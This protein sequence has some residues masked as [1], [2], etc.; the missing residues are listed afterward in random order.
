MARVH[1]PYTRD[2]AGRLHNDT[3]WTKCVGQRPDAARYRER[4]GSDTCKRRRSRWVWRSI[5][6]APAP[7]RALCHGLNCHR[8][9]RR[10]RLRKGLLQQPGCPMVVQGASLAEVQGKAASQTP[11]PTEARGK[12]PAAPA[13]A[14][15]VR[16]PA[17]RAGDDA[18]SPGDWTDLTPCDAVDAPPGEK[19]KKGSQ[20]YVQC[21]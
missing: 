2:G 17:P 10:L 1:F 15:G 7:P 3:R 14:P 8:R 13:P 12:S 6:P 20:T 21:T 18:V 9:R 5:P 11:P 16:A 4:R 19:A